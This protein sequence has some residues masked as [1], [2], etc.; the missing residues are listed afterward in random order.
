MAR[1]T[2]AARLRACAIANVRGSSRIAV[3]R[4]CRIWSTDWFND[5]EGEIARVSAAYQD[6]LLRDDGDAGAEVSQSVSAAVVAAPISPTTS[7][8][9][10]KPRLSASSS[11]ADLTDG[12]L[13]RM[14]T[15]I[16]RDGRLRTDDELFEAL[17]AELGF[18]RRGERITARLWQAIRR[19]TASSSRS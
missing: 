1:R 4:F 5:R 15:W 2:I 9:V 6:A 12:E 17:F 8:S 13:D 7:P 16:A 10:P 11:V 14:L 19:F 3:W 18:Q